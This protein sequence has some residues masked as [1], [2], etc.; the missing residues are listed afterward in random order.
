MTGNYIGLLEM[1]LMQPCAVLKMIIM[2]IN[3]QI[4]Q[5]PKYAWRTINDI[6]G[7]K[8]KQTMIN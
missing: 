4:K 8:R 2:R 5:N 3:L 7:R 6:L 1:L